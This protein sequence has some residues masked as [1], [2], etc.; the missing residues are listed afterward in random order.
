LAWSA[1]RAA[2]FDRLAEIH[3]DQTAI[4]DETFEY[5]RSGSAIAARAEKLLDEGGLRVSYLRYAR[6][7]SQAAAVT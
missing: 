7:C 3:Q 6:A 5:W 1:K 4:S 2:F